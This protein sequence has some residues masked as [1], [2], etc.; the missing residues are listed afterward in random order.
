[1]EIWEQY[2]INVKYLIILFLFIA[3]GSDAK[4]KGGGGA[5]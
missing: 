4:R 1:M 2:D 3:P 5:N